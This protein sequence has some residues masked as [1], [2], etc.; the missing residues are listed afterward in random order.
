MSDLINELRDALL[1]FNECEETLS[2]LGDADEQ[3]TDDEVWA[4][5]DSGVDVA[6]VASRLMAELDA[7]RLMIVPVEPVA[8]DDE[9]EKIHANVEQV[10]A[11]LREKVAD[12]RA[13][14]EQGQ[15]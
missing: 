14:R 13:A 8:D 11:E 3:P 1:V 15:S 9:A 5:D 10:R 12:I 4:R 2:E 6:R 7:G